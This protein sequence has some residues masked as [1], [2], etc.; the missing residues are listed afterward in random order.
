[1]TPYPSP[2]KPRILVADDETVTLRLHHLLL[3]REGF[4][5]SLF[6]NGDAVLAA[7]AELAPDL[8]ILDY[9]LPGKNGLELVIAFRAHPM[10][11]RVPIIV[12]TGYREL[13]LKEELLRAGAN[14]IVLKPFSPRLLKDRIDHFLAL[15]G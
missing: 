7:A 1:M 11:A 9:G 6:D 5:P 13:E 15:A 3:T 10:L 4:E 14:D 2:R 12:V 8:A